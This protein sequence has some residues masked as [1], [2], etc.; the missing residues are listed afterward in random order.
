M[1]CLFL[2][3]PAGE[4]GFP[5]EY[6]N[7]TFA[8]FGFPGSPLATTTTMLFQLT[9]FMVFCVAIKKYH[10]KYWGGWT[11][12]SFSSTRWR[13]YLKVVIPMTI[14]NLIEDWGYNILAYLSG[15]LGPTDVAAISIMFNT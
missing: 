6:E 12:K 9:C 15:S 13:K 5:I 4:Y 3:R 2:L 11:K 7:G 10:A 1:K 14:G 8:G